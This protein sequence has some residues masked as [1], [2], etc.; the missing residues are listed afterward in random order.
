M[1]AYPG[2]RAGVAQFRSAS[3]IGPGLLVLSV[4]G[5]A[6]VFWYGLVSLG[7]AWSTPEYSHGPVIPLLSAY[8][9]LL[10]MRSVPP[11]GRVPAD[12]GPGLLIVAAALLLGVLGNLVLIPDIVTYA[13]IL[14]IWGMVLT[15]FGLRRGWLLWPGVL[16]LVFMLPLPQVIYWKVSTFLQTV[17][18]EIGV[19]LISFIGI[20]VFLDGNIIDL[21]VYKLQVAE[22]CS[23]LRYLFPIMSFSYVFGVLYTGPRWH[24]IVLFLAA[25]PVAV[26]MNSVRIGIIG[27]LVDSYGI[28]QAEGFLHAFEGWII[29][30]ACIAILFGLAVALQWTRP[31]PQPIADTLELDFGRVLPQ[32]W[33]FFGIRASAVLVAA[34]LITL[35]VG[36]AVHAAPE[37][38]RVVPERAP[39]ALFPD[40]IGDWQANGRNRLEPEIE[41]VLGADDYLSVSY[42][43]QAAAPAAAPAAAASAPVDLFIAYYDRQTEGTGIHSPEVCIPGGGWEVSNWERTE[44]PVELAD[45]SAVRLP[46]NRAVIQKGLERQLVIYWFEQRGRKLTNDYLA[47][48]MTVWDA[49]TRGRTDGAL[50]RLVTPMAPGESVAAAED[51]LASFLDAGLV[52]LPRFIPN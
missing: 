49:L 34:A 10:E 33:R 52:E 13:L 21:G 39:L 30:I 37:P 48:A 47:K 17:S 36:V 38:D 27:V 9:F 11:V 8:M 35:G 28:E 45:G 16:H 51:R 6:G 22:A 29:F 40:Q 2:I 1:N 14:W 26:L 44:L 46:A 15:V 25:A 18:S 23:G 41:R 31:E 7:Q 5:A 24:K 32:A 12:R 42:V 20:P 43:N 19:N 4:V 50:V 3:P